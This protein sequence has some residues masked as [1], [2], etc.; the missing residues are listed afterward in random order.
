MELAVFDRNELVCVLRALRAVAE[1]D[2]DFSSAEQDLLRGVAH[3][4]GHDVDLSALDPISGEALASAV[5]DPHKR[6]R[7]VQLAIVTS[8]V[9]GEP[10]ARRQAALTAIARALDV[11]E[12][13][14]RVLEKLVHGRGLAARAD[15]ARRMIGALAPARGLPGLIKMLAVP[16]LGLAVDAKVARRYLALGE[17]PAGTVGR[18]L[19][20]HIKGNGFAFPGEK[21]GLPERG[22]FHDVGHV[23]S[24]YGVD[25]TGEIQQAAFQAGFVRHDGFLFLLFG[26]LQ[27]HVGLRLTP[28]AK[29]EVGLFDVKKVLRAAERGAACSVDISDPSFD[30]FRVA[31]RPLGELR[32]EYGIPSA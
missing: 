6:R 18:G 15:M 16:L 11:D 3:L 22:F 27:F 13:G 31:E 5:V 25:P 21:G 14:V 30:V 12:S 19:Y 1:G 29:G 8:L 4:H 10:D 32:A 24:G 17:L 28:V 26:I 23:L 20:E 7:A 9:E 2:G